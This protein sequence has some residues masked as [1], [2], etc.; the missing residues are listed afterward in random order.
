MHRRTHALALIAALFSALI[1][2]CVP[3]TARSVEFTEAQ[4]FRPDTAD[5]SGDGWAWDQDKATL[6]LTNCEISS[7]A[8]GFTFTGFGDAGVTVVVNGSSTILTDVEGRNG[9]HSAFYVSNTK[10]LSI[11]SGDSRGSLLLASETGTSGN[12]VVAMYGADL[13]LSN[14]DVTTTGTRG[15]IRTSNGGSVVLDNAT[16]SSEAMTIGGS[17][18]AAPTDGIIGAD[19]AVKLING[20]SITGGLANSQFAVKADE[21]FE[22]SD[23]GSVELEL[24]FDDKAEFYMVSWFGSTGIVS[25]GPVSISE[26]KVSI[27]MT[28]LDSSITK[29]D[30]WLGVGLVGIQSAGALNIVNSNVS[31]SVSAETLLPYAYGI[32]ADSISV[33]SSTVDVEAI[34]ADKVKAAELA[35]LGGEGQIVLSG[36]KVREGEIW[37]GSG[38]TILS[39]SDVAGG[40]LAGGVSLITPFGTDASVEGVTVAGSPATVEGGEFVVELPEG[41]ELPTAS[42]IVVTPTD[43]NATV[44]MPASSDGG[45]TW[46]FTVTAEDSATV[47]THTLRVSVAPSTNVGV[48][49]VSVGNTPAEPGEGDTFSL[50]LPAG[51]ELPKAEDISVALA[52]ANATV[53][54]LSTSDGGRTWTFTVTA[55]D[56]VTTATYTLKVDV[57]S[58]PAP[59]P[60]EES[61]PEDEIPETG[62]AA[63]AAPVLAFLAV[64]SLVGAAAAR[65]SSR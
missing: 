65:R 30:E 46:T 45:R 55:E 5:V 32:V 62:D 34:R 20:S 64:V 38:Q 2:L 26:S 49:S 63:S 25:D 27:V 42:D 6:T 18:Y 54:A 50:T 48:A 3:A 58:A 61:A 44:S 33:D 12:G 29:P 4:L 7:E 47:T 1:V 8:G 37:N 59:K 51:S 31:V 21:G 57:A 41:F 13:L 35:A 22:T 17:S 40:S 19:G 10:S 36:C 14:V 15:D 23:G 53:S 60:G 28:L 24:T 39:A 56:G 9:S 11:T 16:L 43:A 52:D